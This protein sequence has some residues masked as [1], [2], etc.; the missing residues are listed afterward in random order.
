MYFGNKLTIINMT[1]ERSM[2]GLFT[3]RLGV[4]EAWF[5]DVSIL[6][7][8]SLGH[9]LGFM[10]R[11]SVLVLKVLG[12]VCRLST[13]LWQLSSLNLKFYISFLNS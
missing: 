3:A 9:G 7:F 5:R 13:S 2:I 1:L 11:V 6:K 4:L 8:E 12:L 10:T